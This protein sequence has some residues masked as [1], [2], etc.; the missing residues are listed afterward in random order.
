I[1]TLY[2]EKEMWELR[3]EWLKKNQPAFTNNQAISQAIFET[4]E[5][6][7][8]SGVTTSGISLIPVSESADRIEVGVSFLAE[9]ELGRIFRWLYDITPPSSFRVV[10]SIRIF[11]GAEDPRKLT[12]KIELLRWYA[13]RNS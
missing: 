5:R 1:Q 13:P 3:G 7:S 2:E 8:I 4:A 9:G 11:P 12:A 10:R 6:P